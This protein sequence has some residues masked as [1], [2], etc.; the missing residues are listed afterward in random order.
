MDTLNEM[1]SNQAEKYGERTFLI[2]QN[3]SFSYTQMLFR[4]KCVA[5]ALWRFMGNGQANILMILDNG[6]D[7][8]ITFFGILMAGGVPVPLGPKSSKERISYI[9]VDCHAAAMVLDKKLGHVMPTDDW[10]IP[11]FF[12]KD[13]S[14]HTIANSRE[15]ESLPI[16]NPSSPAF[17]QYTSGST[18]DSKGVIISHRAVL[19]NIE[20]ISKKLNNSR[21]QRHIFS[22]MMPLFHDMGLVAFGLTPLF[23]GSRLILYQQEALSLYR[24]L[25]GICEHKVTITGAP[26]T[27]LHVATKVVSSPE[28]YDLSSLCMLICGSEPIHRTVIEKFEHF[29]Q[30]QG[31]IKPAYGLAEIALCATLT[32]LSD[33]YVIDSKGIVSCG[34]VIEKVQIAF[35]KED[36]SLSTKSYDSGEILIRTPSLMNGYYGQA[37]M[38]AKLLENGY[39][40]TGDI[41]YL[42][43]SGRLFI[44]GR[45]KNLI[46][47]GGE[48]FSPHDIEEI[49]LQ[50]D[51]VRS[52]A[53]IQLDFEKNGEASIMLVLEVSS[54]DAKKPDVLKECILSVCKEAHSKA[55]YQPHFV[56]IVKYGSIPLTANGKI[57]H[58]IMRQKIADETFPCIYSWKISDLVANDFEV[59]HGIA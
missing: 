27:L 53:V 18:G 16:P 26:N 22:S 42:D 52:A 19:A 31:K 30:A 56:M 21:K 32:D 5:S 50:Y 43:N 37:H 55:R 49:A 35:K 36:G 20:A 2:H 9:A 57:Q 41:G 17:I 29:F 25:E 3:H 15:M 4:T 46:V 8:F 39:L 34:T 1:F 7:F 58:E 24:W 6:P 59:S 45:K 54:R 33:S 47:R 44:L 10:N 51:S 14:N 13:L 12:L 48:K 40:S 11:I 38:T 23:L 28:N